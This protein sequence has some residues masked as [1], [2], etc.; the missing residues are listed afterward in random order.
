MPNLEG[1]NGRGGLTDERLEDGIVQ[2][3]AAYP[4][5][6]DPGKPLQRPGGISHGCTD[7]LGQPGHA[8]EAVPLLP[9]LRRQQAFT[10]MR[11]VRANFF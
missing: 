8:M 3:A 2:S 10:G 1:K 5:L 7:R 9:L 4:G 6:R 11:L